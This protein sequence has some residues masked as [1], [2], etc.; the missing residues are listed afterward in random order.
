MDDRFV[1]QAVSGKG[2]ARRGDAEARK[3][4]EKEYD[5][6]FRKR[7]QRRIAIRAKPVKVVTTIAY[8]AWV[9]YDCANDS[10]SQVGRR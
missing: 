6:I 10:S 5:R 2:S 8:P 1:G 9:F 3:R 7:E 4:Y